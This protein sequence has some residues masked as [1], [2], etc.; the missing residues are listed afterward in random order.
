MTCVTVYCIVFI[1]LCSASLSMNLSEVLPV[2]VCLAMREKTGLRGERKMR[3]DYQR[4]WWNGLQGEVHSTKRDQWMQ[5]I[6]IE[7]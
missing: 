2:Q 1:H 7:P 3:I 4:L 5:R 6:S